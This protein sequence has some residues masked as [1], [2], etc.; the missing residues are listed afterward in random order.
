M[1]NICLSFVFNHQ[2]ERNIPKLRKFYD[3]RF[4]TIRYLSPFSKTT[5]PDIVPIF[6]K[7]IHF[8]GY[9]AQALRHLPRNCDYYIF[10]G[11]DLILNPSLNEHNIIDSLNCNES[12]Y[13]KYLNQY[14]S[15]HLL[16]TN[17]KNAINLQ[18]RNILYLTKI[19][20]LQ[21]MSF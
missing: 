4:S 2:F 20:C 16:G 19:C 8:Q 12:S 1:A 10:C 21:E 13:I 9:F 5:E 18:K 11:D 7:S 15:I 14:G 6:E 3:D 17:L